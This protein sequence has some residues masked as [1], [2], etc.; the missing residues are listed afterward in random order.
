MEALL[1]HLLRSHKTALSNP[2]IW[3][4]TGMG[5]PLALLNWAGLNR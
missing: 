4:L 5:V 2:V 1:D 3:M